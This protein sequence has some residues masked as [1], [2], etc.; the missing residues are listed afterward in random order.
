MNGMLEMLQA[1]ED[2]LKDHNI[3][4]KVELESLPF[5]FDFMDLQSL[6]QTDELY[7]KMNSRGKQLSDYEH[8]KS[9]L[10]GKYKEQEEN[11]WFKNLWKKLDTVWLNYFWRNV[12][13]SFSALDDFYYNFIKHLALMHNIAT[14]ENLP[15]EKL[16]E[17]YGEIRNSESYDL[18]KI[19]YIP[20][21][22]YTIERK[23][24]QGEKDFFFFN[25]SALKFIEKT[26]DTLIHLEESYDVLDLGK[27][28]CP[29]FIDGKITDLFIKENRFTPSLWDTVFYYSFIVFV[30]DHENNEYSVNK[31]KDWLRF[32]RNLIYNTQIQNPENFDSAIRQ[33]YKL[34]KEKF[35]IDNVVEIENAF[36]DR[37]QFEEEQIKLKLL[38]NKDWEETITKIENHIY[39]Y[40]QIRFLLDFSLKG[41][42]DYDIDAFKK[43]IEKASNLFG[44][45]RTSKE[46]ILERFLLSFGDYLPDY[47]SNKIFCSGKSGDLRTKN[48][49]WRLFFKGKK[50][51]ILKKAIDQFDKKITEESLS[52]FIKSQN[53]KETW[54]DLFIKYPKAI[55]FCKESAIRYFSEN[56][57]RLL[58]GVA[59]T[60]YH[61]ELWTYCFFLEHKNKEVTNE[62]MIAPDYFLP[63]TR[64]WFFKD[65][66]TDG[67]PGCYL[68]GFE[69]N[70]KEYKL[71]I[72]YSKGLEEKA[73]KFELRFFHNAEIENRESE[74]DL[75]CC[76]F[77]Y[78]DSGDPEKV[79]RKFVDGKFDTLENEI[80]KV[81]E[82]LNT[83]LA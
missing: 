7:V 52:E 43:Y 77:V 56:K 63:F 66:N 1:I 46:H 18:Q 70:G 42:D 51:N 45:I 10:Q 30:N 12:D 79:Y 73:N 4:D 41:Q 36:F 16:K 74:I 32:T 82:V 11:E 23:N 9:W 3:S 19:T 17:R 35:N 50:V 15:F 29:P 76:D 24:K 8:F 6:N 62:N 53:S 31:L 26:F 59:I 13:A 40:G 58:E 44:D 72:R 60:G 37:R 67:H 14:R 38:K 34:S 49:N 33:V 71:E 80:K 83:P 61:S 75:K 57:I 25:E 39:F 65:K 22:K 69:K 28:I 68:G 21:E 20:F 54:I 2:E 64:F 48:E 81:C 78:D 27:I 5:R 47:K 55:S